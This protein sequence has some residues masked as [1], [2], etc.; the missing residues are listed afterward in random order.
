[1]ISLLLAR[2]LPEAEKNNILEIQYIDNR[3]A[4]YFV[5]FK[6]RF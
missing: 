2:D 4:Q 3:I 5:S 1:M 6:S